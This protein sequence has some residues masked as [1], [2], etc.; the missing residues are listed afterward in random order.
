MPHR[1]MLRLILNDDKIRHGLIL[2]FSD[3]YNNSLSNCPD[4]L[5][6]GVAIE[7]IYELTVNKGGAH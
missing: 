5:N 1:E 7:P 2:A 6:Q 4:H 3:G